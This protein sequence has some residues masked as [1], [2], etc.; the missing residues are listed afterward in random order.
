MQKVTP[1]TWLFDPF[2]LKASSE[3]HCIA[4]YTYTYSQLISHLTVLI[5]FLMGVQNYFACKLNYIPG[6]PSLF[7]PVILTDFKCYSNCLAQ[8]WCYWLLSPCAQIALGILEE[9]TRWRR[10]CGHQPASPPTHSI[11]PTRYE[12]FLPAPICEGIRQQQIFELKG[13]S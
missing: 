1:N 13:I 2:S 10:A 6:L 3:F 5:L 11:L 4:L 12:P 7:L 8:S 9:S